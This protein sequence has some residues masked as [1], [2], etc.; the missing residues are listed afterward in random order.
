[1]NLS[2]DAASLYATTKA[3]IS[4]MAEVLAVEWVEFG[5]NAIAPGLLESEMTEDMIK[6]VGHLAPRNSREIE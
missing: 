6:R 2:K 5:S 3:A 1:L 4:R